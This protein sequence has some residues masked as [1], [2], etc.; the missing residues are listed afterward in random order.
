[1]KKQ[2]K[3][4]GKKKKKTF[5]TDTKERDGQNNSEVFSV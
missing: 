2:Q 4:E 3:K 1:M 5:G